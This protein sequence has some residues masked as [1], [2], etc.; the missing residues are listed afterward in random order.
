MLGLVGVVVGIG[1][2]VF[3]GGNPPSAI[4]TEDSEAKR[5]EEFT[6]QDRQDDVAI[7]DGTYWTQETALLDV[8]GTGGSGIARRGVS[9]D[10]FTHV[11]VADLPAID[12]EVYFYEGW[13]V[14]PGVTDYF[15]TGAMFIREDGQWGLLWESKIDDAPNDLLDYAKVVI[16]RELRD[17]DSAPSPDHVIEGVFEE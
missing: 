5:V 2:M 7:V 4:P 1:L 15:S 11:V 16:T 8:E 14:V 3:R 6:Q 9:D 17:D 12:P 13:L 10:L